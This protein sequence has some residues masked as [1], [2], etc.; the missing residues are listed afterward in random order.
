[1]EYSGKLIIFTSFYKQSTIA[2]YCDS[3]LTTFL[4]LER[5]GIRF[6]YWPR[7][8]D[9]HVERSINGAIAEF[10]EDPEATDFLNIDA[11]ESWGATGI[12]RLLSHPEPIVCAAYKCTNAWNKYVGVIT[13]DQDGVPVGKLLTE[14]SAILKAD[15]VPAGFLR[16]KKEPV[17]KFMETYPDS[18]FWENDRKTFPFFWNEV[19][20]HVFVGM[21]YAFSEKM[22]ALGFDLWIDPQIEVTHWGL[23][24]YQGNLDQHMRKLKTAGSAEDLIDGIRAVQ[25]D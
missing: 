11:D 18:W 20:N 12:L 5:L 8:G 21:D 13:Q 2:P 22:K 19:E 6:D 16:L 4:L 23:T 24:G 15:K 7:K 9:F 10:A 14:N 17:L 25:G 3:I 1:M